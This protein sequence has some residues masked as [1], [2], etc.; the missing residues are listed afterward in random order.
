MENNIA[1]F[2]AAKVYIKLNLEDYN[3]K[4]AEL[5]IN[6]E[7]TPQKSKDLK[8]RFAFLNWCYLAINLFYF[9]IVK[10]GYDF[11]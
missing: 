5:G 10:K 4:K 3:K 7:L 11:Y 6:E 1:T 2:F 8:S 9:L